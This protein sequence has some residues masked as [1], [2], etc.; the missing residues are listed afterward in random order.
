MA[1]GGLGLR[2]PVQARGRPLPARKAARR[3]AWFEGELFEGAEA[4]PRYGCGRARVDAANGPHHGGAVGICGAV[5]R[6]RRTCR[7]RG[8]GR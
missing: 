8:L 7:E 3:L 1:G 5:P 4:Q 6:R 2:V